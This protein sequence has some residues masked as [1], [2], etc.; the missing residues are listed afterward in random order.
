MKKQLLILTALLVV[1]SVAGPVRSQEKKPNSATPTDAETSAQMAGAMKGLRDRLLT[2]SPLEIGLS[3]EDAKARVWGAMIEVAFAE[4]VATLVSLRDGTASLYVSTGGGILGGYSARNEAKRFVE[5][6][7]KHLASMKLTKAFPYPTAGMV[8]FFV[9]TQE[10]VYSFEVE[11]RELISG[12]HP[13]GP[14]F[15]AGNKVM[16]GLR[17]AKERTKP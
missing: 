2:S 13:L 6:S 14:L 10:G 17:N 9:L 11:E 8:K 15:L 1:I 3:T 5:E 12:K 7:E 4:G 16:T